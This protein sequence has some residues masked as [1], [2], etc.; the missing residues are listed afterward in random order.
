MPELDLYDELRKLIGLLDEHEI[1][2][3][4][5]GGLAMAIHARPRSTI[6]IDM[7]IFQNHWRNQKRLQRHCKMSQTRD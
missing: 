7:L 4:L 6:D 2:Y 5:C 3:A 1:D